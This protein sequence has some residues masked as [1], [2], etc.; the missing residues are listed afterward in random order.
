MIETWLKPDI[1]S[2]EVLAGRYTTFRKDRSS[3]RAGGVLIAVDSYFTSEHFTVQVQQ[4]LE[5]LCVKLI[6]PAFA[7]FITC[8]YIPPSSDI[9]IYEQHLS[10][11]TAV[12]S[13][14]S[15]KDRMIVLGDFNLPGTVWSSV[16][17]SSILVP[18]SRHDFVDGLLDLSLSTFS[19]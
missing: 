16:N 7:I 18:M 17:E 2:S 3:R 6:L 10:A 1:L 15:D 4:E 5:F 14:L 13:S 12:S 9:S 8:S 11:L 19:L